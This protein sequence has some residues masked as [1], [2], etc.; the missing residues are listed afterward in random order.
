VFD[1]KAPD[2]AREDLFDLIRDTPLLDWM[3]LT[4][5]LR[6]SR[7]CYLY[8]PTGWP[9]VWLGATCEDQEH[10][11]HRWPILSGVP[12][13]VRF[14]SY[15]PALGPLTLGDTRPEGVICGGESGAGAPTRYMDP[16]WARSIRKECAGADVAFFMKQ[17][18]G[19]KPI[20]ADLLV[21]QYPEGL[22]CHA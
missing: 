21:R 11:D 4:K 22:H 8:L 15:E 17:M 20:P 1:N 2:G 12:A 9:N 14:I 6:I 19:K 13:V 7:R 18:T 5:R 10:F 16:A 3:L